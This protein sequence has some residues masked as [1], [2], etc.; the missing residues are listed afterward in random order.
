MKPPIDECARVRAQKRSCQ[1][2][3]HISFHALAGASHGAS[4][5]EVA[6]ASTDHALR[7]A[8]PLVPTAA[9]EA[10]PSPRQPATSDD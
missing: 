2:S 1:Q 4:H 3:R 9:A 5:M 7:I 10:P 8:R 6:A